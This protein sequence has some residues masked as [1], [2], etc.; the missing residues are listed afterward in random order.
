MY[1]EDKTA[2]KMTELL[3]KAKE[4]LKKLGVE[5][6]GMNLDDEFKM[7]KAGDLFLEQQ[8]VNDIGC[9]PHVVHLASKGFF[10]DNIKAKHALQSSQ[11][12]LTRY[13]KSK[14]K[15]GLIAVKS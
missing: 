10:N 2:E 4:Y 15:H 14:S 13:K 3:V 12:V 11:T 8:G 5:V 7:R 9:A 6:I 1:G